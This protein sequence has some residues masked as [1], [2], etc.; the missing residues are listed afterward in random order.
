LN[1][2][3]A[4]ALIPWYPGPT[5][6]D[7]ER[8]GVVLHTVSCAACRAELVATVVEAEGIR[9]LVAAEPRPPAALREVVLGVQDRDWRQAVAA[10]L[11]PVARAVLEP[12]RVLPQWL[13]RLLPA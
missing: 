2:P 10:V 5:L 3:E 12:G 13:R 6:S 8:A 11:P 1:C 9:A 7:G 4:R